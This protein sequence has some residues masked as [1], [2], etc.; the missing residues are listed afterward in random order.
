MLQ[1][2]RDPN[3]V[4]SNKV[5]ITHPDDIFVEEKK[6]MLQKENLLETKKTQIYQEC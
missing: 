5:E 4:Q 3:E 6:H 2:T 1:S